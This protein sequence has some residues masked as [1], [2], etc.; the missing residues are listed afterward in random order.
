MVCSNCL[1]ASGSQK[2][3]RC[4]MTSY[5]N[6]ECQT[7]HWPTHKI[8]CKPIELSPQKLQL[9][10][11]VGRDAKPITFEENIPAAFCQRDAPRD[12]TS[13]WVG[14]LVDTREEEALARHPGSVCLYCYKPAT[15][16]HTTLAVTLHGNPPTVFVVG[17]PLCTLNR[18]NTCASQAQATMDQGFADPS[19]PARGEDIYHV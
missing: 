10:F 15:R 2:C 7:A 6:R 18:N 8:R 9:H 11:T 12:L 17:Q 4:K 14:N 5:C 13:R 19:F 1:K 16:L 3:G